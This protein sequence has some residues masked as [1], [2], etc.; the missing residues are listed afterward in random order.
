MAD[1]DIGSLIS[2]YGDMSIEELG[3]SLLQRQSDIAAEQ[4][5][6][7]KKNR[8]FQQAMGVLMA[9]QAIFKSAYNK[10]EKELEARKIFQQSNNASQAK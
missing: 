7:D 3:G 2:N 1:N 6:E 4:A 9:G 5:K 8:K 10:R